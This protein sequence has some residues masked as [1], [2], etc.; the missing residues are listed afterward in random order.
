MTFKFRVYPPDLPPVWGAEGSWPSQASFFPALSPSQASSPTQ[1][2]LSRC[3]HPG[4]DVALHNHP[5]YAA[6]A[7]FYLDV[8]ARAGARARPPIS[9]QVC[10]RA[11][12]PADL[13]FRH[14]CGGWGG[15]ETG[16]LCVALAVQDAFKFFDF[17]FPVYKITGRTPRISLD[18]HQCPCCYTCVYA[19]DY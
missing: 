14:I 15:G 6:C 7:V 5:S 18:L 10:H 13:C 16:L 2:V 8:S 1:S 17:E 9:K 19:G 3:W 11:T 4:P 12:P